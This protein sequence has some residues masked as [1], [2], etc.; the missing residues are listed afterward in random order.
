MRFAWRRLRQAPGFALV[1]VLTLAV[2]VGAN[3]AVLSIADA[4][5]F[6]PLPFRDPDR[7][8]VLRMMNA[9]GQRFTNVTNDYL[10]AID[11]NH[12]GLGE[13]GRAGDPPAVRVDGPEGV[14][15]VPA[16]GVTAAYLR[17][18]TPE[19][20]SGRIFDDADTPGRAALL[21]SASWRTRFGSD[22]AI[23][24]KTITLGQASFD[25]VGVLAP[26]V[27]LPT[28]F[29]RKPELVT[30]VPPVSPGARGGQFHPIVRLEPGVTREQAQAEIA[31]L[32]APIGARDPRRAGSMPVLDDI[33]SVV[34]PVARNIT[35][36]ILAAA[37][38]VL[39]IGCAN[40]ANM[41]L[42][43]GRRLERETAV[44]TAL[45]AGRLR[46]V[47]PLLFEALIIGVAAAGLAVAVT[48]LSFAALIDQVPRAAYG[49][50]AVG[51]DRRVMAL[52]L[53]L[54]ILGG[55]VFAVVPAW[56]AARLDVIAL[57][58]SRQRRT[59][60]AARVGRPMVAVQIALA[61]ALVF[62]AVV[63]AR[64]FV[65]VLRVP[66]GFSSDR[67]IQVSVPPLQYDYVAPFYRQVVERLRRFPNVVAVGGTG[68]PP[69]SGIQ[70][71]TSI[72]DPAG[73]RTLAGVVHATPG[74]FEA[75]G[76]H[77]RRGR[78]LSW[79]DAVVSGGAVISPSAA[80]ALFGDADPMGRTVAGQEPDDRWTVVGVVDD[81]KADL[82][83][84]PEPTVYIVPAGRATALLVFVRVS[85]FDDRLL[86]DIRR[87]MRGL[88]PSAVVSVDW[89]NTVLGDLT[90]YK[91]PRFQTMVL[92]SFATIALGL[93]TLGVFA[94][95]A[96][97]VAART[98]ELGI[99]MAIGAEPGSLVRH[100]I[101]QALLPVG[102]GLVAGLAMTRWLAKFAESQLFKVQTDDP[103]TL[104]LASI[105]VVV[106]ALVAAWLPARRAARVNPIV[107]LRTE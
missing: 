5:L 54:A 17:V 48:R 64:S 27:F 63:A 107:A 21:S 83:S 101:R 88:N 22:P 105:V 103:W 33:R 76:I 86:T 73:N 74:Y 66:L 65:D 91:N 68:G 38:L 90:E 85:S 75:L 52:A 100:V 46:V 51:V 4:V 49:S 26:G 82:D 69:L 44:R 84:D 50:A 58:H 19:L 41:L 37:L 3:T 40:L 106:A 53:A 25:V 35:S 42:A 7:V 70:R 8:F 92:A 94:V 72:P 99:R 31:A 102:V 87:A 80:K 16:L 20:A 60:S 98:K 93:T 28:S 1:A 45:G 43:R 32:V 6:R 39:L 78:S 47:R 29:N 11:A 34:Y 81:I 104:A 23:V 79:D 62:G 71:W 9:K 24:G 55:L 77:L 13:V 61:I 30:L 10:D 97:L 12:R 18:L 89:W 14:E 95:I 2:A 57:L 96:F 67:V 36:F 56:R 59:R 15:V